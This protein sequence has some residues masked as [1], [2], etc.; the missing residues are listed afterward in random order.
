[1][2]VKV[3]DSFEKTR[4]VKKTTNQKNAF[5]V[6]RETQNIMNDFYP[7]KRNLII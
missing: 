2:V 5:Y 1:M 4:H 3:K 6:E 7:I